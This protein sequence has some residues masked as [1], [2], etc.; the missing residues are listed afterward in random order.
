[1][2]IPSSKQHSYGVID[3]DQSTMTP[4]IIDVFSA[5]LTHTTNFNAIEQ[6]LLNMANVHLRS[7]KRNFIYISYKL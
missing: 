6:W 5:Y 1:M 4:H 3:V 2:L 7:S